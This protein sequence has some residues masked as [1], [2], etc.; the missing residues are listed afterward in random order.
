MMLRKGIFQSV[1][2][3]V[4]RPISSATVSITKPH[5]NTYSRTYPTLLVLPDGS[6]I[7]MRY[8]EPRAIIRLPLDINTLNDN[9][10]RARLE[11]RK[12]KKKMTVKEAT[13][14]SFD[15]SKYVNLVK[16]KK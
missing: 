9:E 11:L 5:R 8:P 3:I 15:A 10:K 2:Q 7:Q 12:P 16:K 4:K 14:V 6:T 13:S 1:I